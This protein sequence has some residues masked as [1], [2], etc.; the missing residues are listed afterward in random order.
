MSR[1]GGV[2]GPPNYS[3]HPPVGT[4]APQMSSLETDRRQRE[5]GYE[6]PRADIQAL[7]PCGTRN[8]LELGCTTGALGDALKRR[9]PRLKLLG[10]VRD[11][12]GPLDDEGTFDRTHLRRFSERDATDLFQQA[13][14]NAIVVTPKYWS[15]GWHLRRGRMLART[16]PHASR[17]FIGAQLVVTGRKA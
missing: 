9:E 12:S 11:R 1:P 15:S 16:G 3:S 7:V 17:A 13:D 4:I 6:T 10:V 8:V 2:V 14:L 5:H